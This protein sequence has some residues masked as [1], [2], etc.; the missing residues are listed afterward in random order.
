VKKQGNFK[1]KFIDFWQ[2]F[3]GIKRGILEETKFWKKDN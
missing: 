3:F 1:E 2:F